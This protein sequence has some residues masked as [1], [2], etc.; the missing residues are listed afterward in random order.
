MRYKK[1]TAMQAFFTFKYQINKSLGLMVFVTK[2]GIR[3][4]NKWNFGISP[5]SHKTGIISC[6]M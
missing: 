6:N 4:L 3:F 1:G 5:P 2:L